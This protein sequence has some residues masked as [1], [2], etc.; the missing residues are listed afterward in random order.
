[1]RSYRLAGLL[2]VCAAFGAN[3]ATAGAAITTFGSPLSAAA[4][5]NTAENLSY[6]GTNTSLPSSTE[7][8]DGTVIHTY[9]YGADT[10]LWNVAENGGSAGAPATG[11]ALRVK[12]EGCAEPAAGGPAP[13]NQIHFQDI[14]PLAGGGAKVNL[15]SQPFEIPICGQ[16]GAS[17]STVTTYDPIN[18]CVSRGDYVD[19][20]D[21]G[22]YVE[23]YYR[24]GVPYRVL[25]SVSGSTADSFIKGGGTNNGDTMSSDDRAA[26]EGFSQSD[27]EELMLQVELGTGTDATHICSGGTGGLPPPLPSLRISPQT[28]GINHS[29]IVSFAIF[30]RLKP[31][32][33]GVAK[34]LYGTKTVGQTSFGVRPETTSHVPI[35]LASRMIGLIRK[36][37]GVT[38]SLVAVVDGQTFT[39]K[40]TVKIL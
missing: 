40:I 28:D 38:L 25:G 27:N 11:Q 30:C 31:Q 23:K 24:S 6:E 16:N 18:L 7:Y 36:H 37:H 13:L 12:L 34:V 17:G 4:T 10:A 35:R 22:G 20:N 5:L 19:F 33:A 39:Q 29:R 15:T 32:C 1:M 14:T 9:H 21:E 2:A 26:M 3:A 8:P